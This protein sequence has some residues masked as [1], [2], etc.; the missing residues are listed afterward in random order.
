MCVYLCRTWG[1]CVYDAPFTNRRFPATLLDNEGYFYL[2]SGADEQS[3]RNDVWRSTWNLKDLTALSKTCSV[4]LPACGVGLTCLPSTLTSIVN[5]RVVCP[6]VLACDAN[7][8]GFTMLT[9][10]AQFPPRHSAGLEIYKPRI[11]T[12]IIIDGISVPFTSPANSLVLFGGVTSTGELLA[13]TWISGTGVS[14]TRVNAN[15]FTPSAYSGHTTDSKNRI[16]KVAG[17]RWGQWGTGNNGDVFMSTNAGTTEQQTHSNNIEIQ[18][19]LES[20]YS[21]VSS[22]NIPAHCLSVS[23]SVCFICG[24]SSSRYHLD[25]TG[26]QQRAII[27]HLYTALL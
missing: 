18:R 16:F 10:Q 13:D 3:A 1:L 12:R 26:S 14:W 15:S 4:N 7:N 19:A 17:E 20:L 11:N 23:L 24:S 6:A 2:M 9:A 25:P 27:N 22:A 5:N 8:L 21:I